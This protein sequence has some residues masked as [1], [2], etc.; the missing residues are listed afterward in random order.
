MLVVEAKLKN[1]TLSAFSLVLGI[2][3]SSLPLRRGLVAGGPGKTNPEEE[4]REE[5]K[6]CPSVEE[7]RI[8]ADTSH[9]EATGSLML[10]VPY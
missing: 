5:E 8:T 4:K 1:G 2:E 7:T 10:I 9:T 3:T 6:S